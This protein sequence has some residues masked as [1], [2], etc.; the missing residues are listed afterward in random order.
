MADLA[1]RYLLTC[2]GLRSTKG[3]LAKP[4]FER[5]FREYGLPRA[6]RTENGVPFGTAAIHGLS[7]LNVYLM[8]LGIA[9]HRIKPSSPQ[10]NEAHERMHRT[11]KRQAIE[12]VRATCLAQQRN[13]DACRRDCNDERPHEALGQKTPTSRYTT[14]PRS[15]PARAPTPG[16]PGHFLAKTI[17]TAGTFRFGKRI[18]YLVN[19]LTN[20]QIGMEETDDGLWAI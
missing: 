17:T 7:F 6:T 8:Q 1:S 13:F 2:H 20:Q 19:A 14:S 9:H 18:V 12:P 16:Y 5:A 11:L 10:E 4:I 3:A 15:Y